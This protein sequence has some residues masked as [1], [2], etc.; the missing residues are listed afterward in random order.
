MIDTSEPDQLI[1]RPIRMWLNSERTQLISG[2]ILEVEPV[3]GT[4]L[5]DWTDHP[6]TWAR[7][8][9]DAIELVE[10]RSAVER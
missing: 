4:L 8:E 10:A 6:P 1:D 7:A 3:T 9:S 5:V 2:V